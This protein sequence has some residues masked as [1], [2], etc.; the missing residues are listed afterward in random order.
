MESDIT[1]VQSSST[2]TQYKLNGTGNINEESWY[3][4]SQT[5][6]KI[7]AETPLPDIWLLESD[8][9]LTWF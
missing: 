6:E 4:D 5:D 9:D 7:K 2:G 8:C 3:A 1:P